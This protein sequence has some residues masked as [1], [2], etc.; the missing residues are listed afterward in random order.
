MNKRKK[1]TSLIVSVVLSVNIA[2][3]LIDITLID[4]NGNI[5]INLINVTFIDSYS[6]KN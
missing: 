1:I 3:H 5:E 4:N 2:V 6:F